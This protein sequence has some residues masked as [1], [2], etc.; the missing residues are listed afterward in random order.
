MQAV[1]LRIHTIEL[2]ENRQNMF[3]GGSIRNFS[4]IFRWNLEVQKIEWQYILADK[5]D[6]ND[7][8]SLSI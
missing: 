3:F 2:S 4:T 8:D 6:N 5:S 7:E 1:D